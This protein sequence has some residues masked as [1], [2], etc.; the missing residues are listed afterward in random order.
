MITDLI[1]PRFTYAAPGGASEAVTAS[2]VLAA[3]AKADADAAAALIA[4]DEA[5]EEVT[6]TGTVPPINAQPPAFDPNALTPEQLAQVAM[7]HGLVKPQQQIPQVQHQVA[8]KD[9]WDEATELVTQQTGWA[10]P[11]R[12]SYEATR[13]QNQRLEARIQQT[14]E[15][16]EVRQVRPVVENALETA[17]V[18]KEQANYLPWAKAQI[19]R[20][21]CVNQQTGQYDPAIHNFLATQLLI[22]SH[23]VSQGKVPPAGQG[24]KPANPEGDTGAPFVPTGG[25][26]SAGEKA[27]FLDFC[28]NADLD[29][30]KPASVKLFKE[31]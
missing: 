27:G 20:E 24:R 9:P 3:R 8:P 30:A 4:E 26:I 23:A 21:A 15:L 29:P 7:T 22:G 1:R 19:N 10:D 25:G 13:I 17:G 2:E 16:I 14:Q 12:I 28:K 31:F 5:E 11:N 18:P 6:P